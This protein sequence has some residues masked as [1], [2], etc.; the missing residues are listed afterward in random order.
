MKKENQKDTI[1][2]TEQSTKIPEVTTKSQQENLENV[3][4][5]IL[6]K[7]VDELFDDFNKLAETLNLPKHELFVEKNAIVDETDKSIKVRLF[8]SSFVLI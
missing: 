4:V 1:K 2:I 7:Q 8:M 3:T 6:E 5:N